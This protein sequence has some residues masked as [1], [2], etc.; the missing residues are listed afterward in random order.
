[1][2]HQRP[3]VWHIW[4][5]RKRDGFHALV[6]YHKLCEGGGKGRRLLESLRPGGRVRSLRHDPRCKPLEA[7]RLAAALRPAD[8]DPLRGERRGDRPHRR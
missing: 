5:G 2:F 1:M 7:D 3:F 4:D 6:N 8:Q